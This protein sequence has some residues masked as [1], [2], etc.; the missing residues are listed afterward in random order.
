MFYF[1]NNS[2]QAPSAVENKY[3][4]TSL[5]IFILDTQEKLT[6]FINMYKEDFENIQ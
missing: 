5:Y 1:S 3:K 6:P 2:S 4:T